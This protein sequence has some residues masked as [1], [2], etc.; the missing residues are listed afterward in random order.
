MDLFLVLQAEDNWAACLYNNWRFAL[1]QDNCRDVQLWTCDDC[2]AAYRSWLCS[3]IFQRCANG[4]PLQRI[5]VC[6]NICFVSCA[7][8]PHKY[9]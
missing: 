2:R 5:P 7:L 9:V 6:R 8:E 4:D 1:L 3:Q